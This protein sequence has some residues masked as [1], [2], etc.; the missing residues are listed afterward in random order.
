MRLSTILLFAFFMQASASSY[1]QTITYS[2][3]NESL[4]NVFKAIKQQ[5]GYL[6]FYDQAVVS[7]MRKVSVEAKA[8]PLEGFV[9]EV[10]KGMPLTYA[11]EN[12]TI[13]I[14]KKTTLAQLLDEVPPAPQQVSGFVKDEKGYPVAEV[15]VVMLPQNRYAVTNKEGYFI[16]DVVNPGEYTLQFSHI[17][18]Q[19]MS[20]KITLGE[21]AYN[22]TFTIKGGVDLEGVTIS[23]G[24][25]KIDPT[26]VTGA[27]ALITARDIAASPAINIMERLEGKVAGV[28]FDV[29]NNRIQ[30]RGVNNLNLEGTPP[31]IVIDGF[32]AIDQNLM[33]NPGTGQSGTT[34]ATN[35]TILNSFNPADIE[36]ISFL[37]DAA[38]AAIW[39]SRA[40]NGV[41][42]IET[43]KGKKGA[44][45]LVFGSALSVSSPADLSRLDVMNS[46]QYID[47]EQEMFD[48]NFFPNPNDHWRYPEVSDA[49]NL[50]F[51]A[52]SGKI[53]A[54]ERDAKLAELSLRNNRGQLE[55][56]MLQKAITQQYNL[57]VSGA[58][59]NSTYYISG[60]YSKDRPVFKNNSAEKY[61]LNANIT[62]DLFNKR[63]KLSTALTQGFSNSKVN[64]A[65]IR[66][67]SQGNYGLRPYD[68]LVDASGNSVDRYIAFKKS[69]SDSLANLG[70]LPWSYNGINELDLNNT[71]YTR[72]ETRITSQVTVKATDWLDV[73]VSGM[74]QRNSAN[75][76]N[77]ADVE[78][79][80]TRDMVNTGTVFLTQLPTYGVPMGGILK[81][82]NSTSED[83]SLRFQ[84][85]INKT[86]G[87]HQVTFIAGSEIRETNVTG[88]A[89]IRY[90][91]DKDAS[92]GIPVNPMVPYRTI[93]GYSRT[94][95]SPNEAVM[96]D[97][98]RYLSY[99][100][101]GSYDYKGKYHATASIRYDD[102][103]M[104]GMDRSNRALPLW[105]AGAKWDINKEDFM[106]NVSWLDVLALRG[107]YG[108]AGSIPASGSNYTLYSTIAID[109]ITQLPYGTVGLP[110]NRGLRWETS[111]TQNL[112]VDA[113]FFASRLTLTLDVYR[114]KSEGILYAFP[115]NPVYGW[116]DLAYNTANMK[117]HGVEVSIGG[118]AVRTRNWTWSNNFNLAYNTNKVTDSRFPKSML[119]ENRG[120]FVKG[121]AADNMWVYRWA[122]L[123]NQGQSQIYTAD[124]KIIT[125]DIP[126]YEL[127]ADDLKSVGRRTPPFTGGYS[128]T[129]RYKNLSL[130]AR[131]VIYL[132][133]V[134]AM[135][136]ITTS[137]YPNGGF[138]QGFLTSNKALAD[139]WRQPGDE[140]TT[141]VPGLSGINFESI[142]RYINSDLN[143]I[144]GDNIRLQQL[145]L[146]YTLNAAAIRSLRIVKSLT[147]GATVGNL[148]LIWK[149]NREG[150]DPDYMFAGAYSS[151][152]PATTYTFNV[153]VSF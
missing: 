128:P 75:M 140:A 33:S 9:R 12:K 70:Y 51:N 37:K 72:N 15:V 114:K 73:A 78:S 88:E 6:V 47:L 132:G 104:L 66:S 48:K 134:V 25:Q 22:A 5:T 82:T 143:V 65:A 125:S 49:V 87:Q 69:T 135:N 119:V 122:G 117:S 3:K 109:P 38:A 139:R 23:T 121:Y 84:V 86:F 35:N 113:A 115:I 153:N 71:L 108:I 62:N 28:Y 57:S 98:K 141:N 129:I 105:S 96:V 94:L 142:E 144:E 54:A 39:G 1:S 136:P 130:S 126:S 56:Y 24:Y 53:S 145:T 59:E 83:K 40:A 16:F 4:E 103:S 13:I 147:M 29:R 74:Y 124:G 85:N 152:R 93:Y 101:N 8:Q 10:I 112:G 116:Q 2:C 148:G 133:H 131:A 42:V 50:M 90:G 52:Q 14:S 63:V 55:Q 32:P 91:F 58:G 43:K 45:S 7:G 151:L 41:I 20:Q 100:G 149:K 30:V 92:S 34:G 27:V 120:A 60:N 31:L 81:T 127:S 150:V 79:Y 77:L 36:S 102:Y 26:K 123:D 11:F 106:S 46:A 21:E 18:Y 107:S 99:Y 89:R 137:S 97:R 17:S 80:E 67:L 95:P 111:K 64:N 118:E 44:S 19:K 146:N 138:Y 76:K 68:Q 110:G 61:F